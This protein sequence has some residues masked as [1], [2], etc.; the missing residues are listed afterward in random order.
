MKTAA[1]ILLLASAIPVLADPPIVGRASVVDGDTIDI[2]GQRIRFNGI[3]APETRQVC[4]DADR[5]EYRCGKVAAEALNVFLAKSRPTRCDFVERDRYRRFVGNCF[6]ADGTSVS[7]WMVRS[8]YALDW[9]R[10]SKGAFAA[11]QADARIHRRGIWIGLFA[12]P[13]EWRKR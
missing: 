6:R 2:Q 7:E 10:Y 12:T 3:D 5:R 1:L 4:L 9:P 13:W 11:Q 8:G